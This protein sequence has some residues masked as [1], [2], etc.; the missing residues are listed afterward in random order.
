MRLGRATTFLLLASTVTL[1][2]ACA[3]PDG[4]SLDSKPGPDASDS[5]DSGGRDATTDFDPDD[6]PDDDAGPMTKTCSDDG[7]CYAK[8]PVKRPLVAVSASSVDDAWMLPQ[9]SNKLLH[10]DGTAMT[11]AYTQPTPFLFQ[12]IWAQNKDNLWALGGGASG[13]VHVVRYSSVGGA[14]PAFRELE[15]NVR[16]AEVKMVLWGTPAGDALWMLTDF[17]LYRV[18]EESS[19]A[20]VE[21]DVGPVPDPKD[22]FNLYVWNSVWGFAADDV[23]LAGKLC[24]DE[25]GWGFCATGSARGGLAHWDGTSWTISELSDSIEVFTIHGTSPDAT[26]QQLWLTSLNEVDLLRT[27]RTDLVPVTA[28]GLGK[29]TFS[30]ALGA[31]PECSGRIGQAVS[32]TTAWMAD[33]VLVCRWNGTELVP[34]RT[35]VGGSRIIDTVSSIWAKGDETWVVGTSQSPWGASNRPFAAWRKAADAGADE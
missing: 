9:E 6:D 19:A 22:R 10:W 1:G 26:E 29:P 4:V 28:T 25:F 8:V 17:G 32:A 31:A 35:T 14:P 34:M 3:G 20:V 7:F 27:V 33:S 30:H 12:G 5:L 16:S 18:H 11:V 24:H 15:T 23:Y 13:H 21:D 2:F